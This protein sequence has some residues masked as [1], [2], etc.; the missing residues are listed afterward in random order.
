MTAKKNLHSHQVDMITAFLNSRLGEKVYIE[1]PL[2]FDNGNKNQ[3]FLLLQGLYGLKQAARL[4]FNTFRDEMKKLGFLQSFYNTALY[5]NSQGT[6][7]AVYV[8]DLHIVGP[9][10][11]FI[12]ELKAQLASKFKTTDLG[13]TAHYLG[14]EV[15]RDNDNIIVTQT[16]YIDQLL[17]THQMSNCNPVSTPMLEGLCLTP[18]NDDFNPDPKDVSAYERFTGSL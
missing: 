3:I 16:V 9:D 4:W 7:V 12:N 8:D 5:F 13:P 15:S 10:F 11:S 6:H 18:A 1:Q 2:F 14:M 17:E